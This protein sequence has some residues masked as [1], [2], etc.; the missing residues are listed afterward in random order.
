[1]SIANVTRSITL[2]VILATYITSS[3]ANAQPEQQSGKRH[4]PP[5]EAI[6]ACA[7]QDEGA[8]CSFSGRRGD[9]TGSCIVPGHDQDKLACAPEGGPPKDHDEQ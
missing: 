1:M 8:A 3:I 2:A 6:D 7:D 9:V 5:P 4:G